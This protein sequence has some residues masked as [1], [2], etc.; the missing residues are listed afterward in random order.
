M[1]KGLLLATYDPLLDYHY[2]LDSIFVA[3]LSQTV[4][5]FIIGTVHRLIII[6]RL[7]ETVSGRP[8]IGLRFML[9]ISWTGHISPGLRAG[10]FHTQTPLLT[11]LQ[12][13]IQTR[14][15]FDL[16]V[17][18]VIGIVEGIQYLLRSASELQAML[19]R[20]VAYRVVHQRVYPLNCLPP[21]LPIWSEVK[22][23]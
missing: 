3:G 20:L 12:R 8:M 16:N 18:I 7:S 19:Q 4:I 5:Y 10:L 22:D 23:G 21:Y 9:L 1:I 17:K 2:L 6:C 15:D 14:S 13:N 11:V